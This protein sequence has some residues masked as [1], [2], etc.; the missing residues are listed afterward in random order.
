MDRKNKSPQEAI[1]KNP[2][3]QVGKSAAPPHE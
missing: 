1:A 2:L 3:I